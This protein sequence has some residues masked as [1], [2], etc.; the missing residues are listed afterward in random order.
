[1][2]FLGC[3]RCMAK[4]LNFGFT[5]DFNSTSELRNEIDPEMNFGGL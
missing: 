1:M 2:I 4:Y 3:I 5:S